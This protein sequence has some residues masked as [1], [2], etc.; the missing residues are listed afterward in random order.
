M[1][2]ATRAG[3]KF[4]ILLGAV[5]V[6]NHTLEV[7]GGLGPALSAVRGVGMWAVTFV[8]FGFAS[9]QVSD[10]VATI[11]LGMV[12]SSLSAVT[13]TGIL[14]LCAIVAGE[15]QSQPLPAATIAST[16][17]SHLA[18]S[19][20]IALL[21]S[22]IGGCVA[23]ALTPATKARLAFGAGVVLLLLCAA[24]GSIVHASFLPRSQ[25]PAFILFGLP[26]MAVALAAVAPLVSATRIEARSQRS[27]TET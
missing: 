13:G 26:A 4:G 18:G 5:A 21:V 7:F 10:R 3:L 23:T 9:R 24:L 1:N 25:R 8:L 6:V 12:A 22:G 27:K 11:P 19:V 20:A 16:G 15:V 14:I 17:S 2:A